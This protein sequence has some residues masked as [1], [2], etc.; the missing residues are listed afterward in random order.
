MKRFIMKNTYLFAALFLVHCASIS[1]MHIDSHT[2]QQIIEAGR[3]ANS[4]LARRLLNAGV[5]INTPDNA[6][7]Y[8]MLI[9]AIACADTD[10]QNAALKNKRLD[11][12]RF[13]IQAGAELQPTTHWKRIPLLR[14][15]ENEMGSDIM[16]L[17]V[18]HHV[19]LNIKD[20]QYGLTALH[21]A[22]QH[23]RLHNVQWLVQQPGIHVNAIDNSGLTPLLRAARKHE[24]TIVN[25]L[26][27]HN[28]DTRIKAPFGKSYQDLLNAPL[29]LDEELQSL[30]DTDEL[31]TDCIIS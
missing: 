17:L 1:S 24:A 11:F 8:P 14:A 12:I 23:R 20:P 10:A 13:W 29:S 21:I 25:T 27:A 6:L 9:H 22:A 15:A 2:S 3:T 5:A 19:N 30:E 31:E 26:L 4:E 18:Q 28:A 16:A 7:H